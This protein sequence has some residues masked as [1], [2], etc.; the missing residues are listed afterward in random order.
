MFT[1]E[2]ADPPL[3]PRQRGERPWRAGLGNPPPARTGRGRGG[4]D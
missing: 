1:A 2:D 4:R 3:S